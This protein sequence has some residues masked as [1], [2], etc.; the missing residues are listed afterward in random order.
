VVEDRTPVVE[1]RTPVVEER[2][3]VVEE[4]EERARLEITPADPMLV[5]F[6]GGGMIYGDLDTHDATCRMLAERADI[7]VLAL[8][9]RLA[10]EHRHP[11]A[12]E[13]CWAGFQWAVE[14]A[15]ELGADP[16]RVAVGGDSAGAY[17]AAVVAIKAA[18]AGVPCVFQLLVYPVTNHVDLSESRRKFGEGF[19]LTH[20]FM[21]LAVESYLAPTDDRAD[22]MVSVQLTEKIPEGL[23]PA[24]V[25]TAGFDPLRDEGEVYA[26]TLADAGV[27][28]ELRRYP[29]FIHGFFNVVGVGRANRAAVAEIAAKLKA[30]IRA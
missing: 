9:Y 22:P 14:H 26:R 28:V 11:A 10:P 17:L 16:H 30:G 4:R 21:D 19:Y 12:V 1:D 29:G 6:H 8:E 24:L 3:P 15:D 13:D 2:T 20:A 18:E 25:V 7:R 23:A 5:F 27:S